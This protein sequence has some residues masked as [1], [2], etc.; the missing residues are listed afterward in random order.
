[1]SMHNKVKRNCKFFNDEE[2]CRKIQPECNCYQCVFTR[3]EI[4]EKDLNRLRCKLDEFDTF[5]KRMYN[6]QI[7]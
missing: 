2:T 5:F 3:C 6:E 1:M 4:A 7:C